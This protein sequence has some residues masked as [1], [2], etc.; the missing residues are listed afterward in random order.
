[1]IFSRFIL[2]VNCGIVG[3]M[4]AYLSGKPLVGNTFTAI[5]CGGVGYGV[6][7]TLTTKRYMVT[8]ANVV[9]YTYAHIKEDAF[10]LYGFITEEEKALFLK[11]INVDGVGPKTALGIMDRGINE[12]VSAVRAADVSF[13]QSVPRVGKKSAQKIIIDL[14]SKLGGEELLLVEPEGVAKDVLEALCALGFST[15][16]SSRFVKSQD[17]SSMRLE[18]AVKLGI[19]V[20]TQK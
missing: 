18:D 13:F 19:Q 7:V 12:I 6:Q 11:L 1:M 20:L 17:L 3:K 10:D 15:L 4:I 2:L 8:Q 9:L 14:K 16:E 5:L